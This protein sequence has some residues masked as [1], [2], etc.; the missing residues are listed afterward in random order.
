M[1]RDRRN[2][3]RGG[4]RKSR[5]ETGVDECSMEMPHRVERHQS[6]EGNRT[7]LCYSCRQVVRLVPTSFVLFLFYR[8]VL[9]G[10]CSFVSFKCRSSCTH[11]TSRVIL[12]DDE[13][14][15]LVWYFLTRWGGALLTKNVGRRCQTE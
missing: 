11:E 10:G 12:V 6:D 8:L 5:R 15:L 3:G 2:A 14:S 13:P 7:C 4:N 9:H 1:D